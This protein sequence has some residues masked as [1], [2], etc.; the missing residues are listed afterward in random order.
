MS[1][2]D[3]VRLRQRDGEDLSPSSR[4]SEREV[5][6]QQVAAFLTGGGQ[7]RQIETGRT[8]HQCRQWGA[9]GSM[10]LKQAEKQAARA[11]A[12]TRH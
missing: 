7:I 3:E 6:S 2:T 12:K 4:A 10:G 9:M 5:I 1:L 11:A 8:R